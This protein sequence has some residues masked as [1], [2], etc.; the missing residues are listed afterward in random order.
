MVSECDACVNTVGWN[1]TKDN[2]SLLTANMKALWVKTNEKVFILIVIL[3]VTVN[4]QLTIYP[5]DRK[6]AFPGIPTSVHHSVCNLWL[7][8]YGNAHVASS[9]SVRWK[10]I[11]CTYVH[12]IITV[13]LY[14]LYVF[15]MYVFFSLGIP[16]RSE[17]VMDY[18][19]AVPLS[20]YIVFVASR[21]NAC[22]HFFTSVCSL[23]TICM[24]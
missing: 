3:W 21:T 24:H 7:D 19:V 13:L 23:L 10:S 5:E 8:W 16:Q 17:K 20:V 4:N 18:A 2:S 6:N 1:A 12:A 11:L 14:D 9:L 22:W 15:A